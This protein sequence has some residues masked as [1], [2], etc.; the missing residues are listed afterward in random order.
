PVDF[1]VSDPEVATS[2][3]QLVGITLNIKVQRPSEP[4]R[5]ESLWRSF[6][7]LAR[8]D[9]AIPEILNGPARQSIKVNVAQFTLD[10]L[11]TD[12][13]KLR[14]AI[15]QEMEARAKQYSL[16]VLSVDVSN[17]ALDP[18]YA[19]E[20]QKRQLVNQQRITAEQE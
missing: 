12:R 2:E 16:D 14:D 17:V 6:N 9:K 5:V 4:E 3:K 20:L 19:E 13:N 7:N 1:E 15:Y 18:K 8:D 11:L 10:E